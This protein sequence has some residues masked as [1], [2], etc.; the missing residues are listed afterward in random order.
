M[1]TSNQIKATTTAKSIIQEAL[2]LMGALSEGETANS[3]QEASLL[4]TLNNLCVTWQADG[5]N[6]FAIQ[7]MGVFLDADRNRYRIPDPNTRL[8]ES[9]QQNKVF[10]DAASGTNILHVTDHVRDSH[11]TLGVALTTQDMF[12]STITNISSTQITLADNLPEDVTAGSTVF[13]Y[14]DTPIH[15]PMRTLSGHI[16][17]PGGNLIPMEHLSREEY[18]GLTSRKST[19]IPLQFYY[20]TKAAYGDI[21]IWPVPVRNDYVMEI[22]V[23]RQL[24]T[25]INVADDV[26]YPA[27]W[28]M[29]LATNLAKV[30]SA[31]Y[32][33]PTADYKRLAM[34]AQEYYEMAK[35]FDFEWDTSLY[36]SPETRYG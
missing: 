4:K 18:E 32:G 25:A 19:G 33:V 5:L 28:F 27:E 15:R 22:H 34:L 10:E 2:E 9:Y 11:D 3:A 31:K 24:D 26:A 1:A 30:S 6:L 23:Q 17:Q 29:P 35:G 36:M 21:Y 14:E 7:A 8:C 13:T 20:D 12:W 16:H